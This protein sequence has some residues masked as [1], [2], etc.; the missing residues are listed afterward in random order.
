[1]RPPDH[2]PNLNPPRPGGGSAGNPWIAV[3]ATAVAAVLAVVLVVASGG[4]DAGGPVGMPDGGGVPTADL[5]LPT[6]VPTPRG[7]ASP[8]GTASP[9]TGDNGSW[10]SAATDTDP[11]TPG[12]WFG[13]T[14]ATTIQ[15]RPYTQLAQDSQSCQA[16]EPDL[17]RLFGSDC[18]GIVRSL[19]TDGTK[20]YV[21]SL[22]VVSFTD[23]VAARRVSDQ[24]FVRGRDGGYVSFIT[25]P[26]GS[27]VKFS[28]RTA[29]WV[30][31]ITQGHYMVVIEVA[32]ADGKAPDTGSE[33]VY[34][35]LEMVPESHINAQMWE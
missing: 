14:G 25:P 11:F 15:G 1:M 26:S 23:S 21:G 18:L 3:G 9:T 7:T 12:E 5:D 33:Q 32:R 17:R 13:M 27:G 16:A 8:G 30:G 2:N 20:A 10:D 4:G 6:G 31:T 28:E 35:D 34:G 29:T 19:W 24:L 22:S